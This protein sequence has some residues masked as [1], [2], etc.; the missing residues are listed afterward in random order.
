MNFGLKVTLFCVGT[1]MASI[2]TTYNAH[3]DAPLMA[4]IAAICGSVGGVL[5]GAFM[6][7]P[8]RNGNGHANGVSAR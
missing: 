4:Y 6:L 8:P 1:A 7:N 3:A 2:A 5:V